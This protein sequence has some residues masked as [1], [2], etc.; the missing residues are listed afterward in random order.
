MTAH[1]TTAELRASWRAQDAHTAERGRPLT[2][3][4]HDVWD[5][6][7]RASRAFQ[8]DQSEREIAEAAERLAAGRGR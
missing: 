6:A 1:E 5:A 3:A 2:E 4:E 8:R 7:W